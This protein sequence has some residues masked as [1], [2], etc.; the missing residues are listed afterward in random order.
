MKVETLVTGMIQENC[1]LLYDENSKEAA[2]IDPGAEGEKILKWIDHLGLNV[3]M[4]LN[5]HGHYDHVGANDELRNALDAPIYIGE[6]D[7]HMLGSVQDFFGMSVHAEAADHYVKDGDRLTLAGQTIEVIETPGHTTGGVVFYLPEAKIAFVGD[8]IF[9]GTV[10][11]TDLAGGSL[12]ALLHSIQKK[13][14]HVPDDVVI[15]SGHGPKTDFGSE[16]RHNPYFRY[17]A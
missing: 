12:E 6:A 17:E 2:V 9:K 14:A 8:T 7:G 16:R 10:G 3:Q 1:Y 15:Y 13:L 4:I 11:R 5:T